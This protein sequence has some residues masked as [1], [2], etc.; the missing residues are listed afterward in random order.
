MKKDQINRHSERGGAGVKFVIILAVLIL[1]AHAGYN[2]IPVRYQAESLQS[3]MQTAVVQ[4]IALP[5]KMNPLDNVKQRIQQA[6]RS[7]DAPPDTF[8]SV[9]QQGVAIQAR[10]AYIKAVPILPFGLYTYQ[11][12]F[13]HTATPTGF[14]MKQ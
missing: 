4:G 11:Y 9:T 13:D 8:V 1:V 10:V 6:I 7:N 14:L 2:Y 3:D 12:Q 5:G